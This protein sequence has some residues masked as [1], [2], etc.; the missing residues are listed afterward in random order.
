VMPL[1]KVKAKSQK[2]NK[3]FCCLSYTECTQAGLS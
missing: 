2:L 1:L 3:H